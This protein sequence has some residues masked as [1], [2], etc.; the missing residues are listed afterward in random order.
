MQAAWRASAVRAELRRQHS[1]ATC[2]QVRCML[3]YLDMSA[4]A[5]VMCSLCQ[6]TSWPTVVTGL[7]HM[8]E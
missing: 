2:I 7:P 6:Q 4:Q 5:S 1:A 8:S 3:Q